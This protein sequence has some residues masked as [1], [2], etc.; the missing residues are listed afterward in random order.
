MRTRSVL[1]LLMLW[2]LPAPG[3]AQQAPTAPGTNPLLQEWTTP[4]GVPP[5]QD[6]K[7]EHFP[8]AFKQAIAEQ[9]KEVEA[10]AQNPEPPTFA[11]TIEAMDG[12]GALMQKVSGVF[13]NLLSSETNDQLQ[14]MNRQLA[15]ELAALRDDVNLNSALWARVKSIWEQRDTLKLAPVQL[16]LVDDTYKGFVRSGANLPVDKK[17]QLRKINAELTMLGVKFSENLLHDTNGWKLVIDNADDLAGLP[18]SVKAAGAETAKRAGM[19]GKWVYTLQVPSLTPFLQY[20][21]MRELRQQI[22]QAYAT[23]CDHGDEYDNKKVVARTAAL[24]VERAQLLGYKTYADF[25]IEENMAKT[26]QRVYDL[27]NQLWTPAR[28]VALKEAAAMQE[29]MKKE[30]QAFTVE[31]WDW[32]YYA[33]KV[34]KAR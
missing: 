2:S 28:G 32:H 17:D 4:F 6:I 13:S 7:P 33:E 24:R 16:K 26:P 18:D 21:D 8:P 29:A 14:A 19:P 23:R 31:P 1:L 15:P 20:S 5:F 30:G 11:N 12:T 22:L 9:R 27:L 10:I 25:V 34:R 3:W